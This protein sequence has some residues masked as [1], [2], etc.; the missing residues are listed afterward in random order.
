M[1]TA[2]SGAA[3]VD[4]YLS[5]LLQQHSSRLKDE[6]CSEHEFLALVSQ[7]AAATWKPSAEAA[8]LV[9]ADAAAAALSPGP[10]ADSVLRLCADVGFL[11]RGD[12]DTLRFRDRWLHGHLAAR[13]LVQLLAGEHSDRGLVRDRAVD[14]MHQIG[15]PAIPVLVAALAIRDDAVGLGAAV[16]LRRMG[17]SAVASLVPALESGNRRVRRWVT[18]ALSSKENANAALPALL[19]VL[20]EDDQPLVVAGAVNALA[21][22][23]N[24]D[25]EP[26]LIA[27][28][29]H[30]D[31]L[32][33]MFVKS[34]LQ[35]FDSPRA[36]RALDELAR[37][38]PD[39]S[40]PTAA[41]RARTSV[42]EPAP[43]TVRA[44][45]WGRPRIFISYAKENQRE[46]DEMRRLLTLADFEPWIDSSGLLA[47][48]AWEPRLRD[49]L[50]TSDFVVA[51]LSEQTADGYQ[52]TELR[53][54]AENAPTGR[55]L[56]VPYVLPCVIGEL[57]GRQLEDM[58]PN[59][60]RGRDIIRISNFDAS[61]RILHE[62]LCRHTRSAGLIVPAL[63]RST[64]RTDFDS[65]AVTE[66]IVGRN[67]F[68]NE[69]NRD[70]RPAAA[71]LQP[72]LNG[73]LVEDRATG[74]VWTR[75]C[76][77]ALP[78]LGQPHARMVAWKANQ[79]RLGGADDWRLP[80]LDEAMS[81][82]ARD[83]N[84]KRLFIAGH[85]SDD[86]YV[87]TCDTCA[88]SSAGT[89][90]W[91]VSYANGDCQAIPTD[92]PVP[93]RLVRTAWEHLKPIA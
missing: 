84:A 42:P 6:S 7:L 8:G 63:L 37:P 86:G 80:T 55:Q 56:D 27:A 46:A 85:F 65:T 90:V 40:P 81:I 78:Y 44:S 15:A 68:D 62:T 58:L 66:T 31:P 22:S 83:Q 70:G 69:R 30:A 26:G 53:I 61:W 92:G 35:K 54:A 32:V 41:P 48:D 4:S 59:A 3:P 29:H 10:R 17:A 38:R 14:A 64:P 50:R 74:R 52:A 51:L 93:V 45:G 25:A 57:A 82:M 28:V 9:T 67:F 39:S 36:R 76:S 49:A 43:R 91:A 73:A 21:E 20:E 77:P 34:A 2:V 33:R 88:S 60:A 89:M 75:S 11:V 18:E 12:G 5:Y 19:R 13:H 79:E 16:A 24:P 87:L 71:T 72:L 23:Q 1:A 47:G